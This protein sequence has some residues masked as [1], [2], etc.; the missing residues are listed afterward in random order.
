VDPLTSFITGILRKGRCWRERGKVYISQLNSMFMSPLSLEAYAPE[1]RWAKVGNVNPGDPPGSISHNK[2]DGGRELYLFECSQDDTH[3][4]IYRSPL[5][6][7][8]AMG[9]SRQVFTDTSS[10]EV[11]RELR[12]GDEPYEMTVKMDRSPEARLI[13]FIHE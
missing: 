12:K 10:W 4:I 7:D 1:G 5:G 8:I 9:K 11:L 2:P 6:L 3:S 13:R